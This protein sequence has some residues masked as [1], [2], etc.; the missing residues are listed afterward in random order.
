MKRLLYAIL[1]AGSS[2]VLMPLVIG[3]FFLLYIGIAFFT[4]ETL[5]TLMALTGKSFM[6]AGLL[7]LIPLNNALRMLQESI[8]A[9]KIRRSMAGKTT[10]F[11]AA[12]FDET[13]ELPACPASGQLEK[14][15][16]AEGYTTNRSA[17]ALSAWRGI[18]N[19]PARILL[20]AGM[21]CLFA[22]ILI[23]T[24]TR[25]SQRQMIIEG[26]ALSTPSGSGANV[27][28]ITLANA[29]GPILSRILTIEVASSAS[30][31]RAFGLYPP[32]LYG[33][34][35][36]YPRYLGLALFLGFTA[37]DMQ[38]AY[39]THSFLN[40]Y[41]PGKEDSVSIPDSPYRIIF[42]IPEPDSSSD[43]YISYITGNITLQFKVM[44]DKDAVW[45]GSLPAGGELVH[46]GYRLTLPDVRRMVVTDFIG[47]YGVL[48]IWGAAFLFAAAVCIWLPVRLF[49]PRRE[50]LFLYERDGTRACSRAEGRVRR[51]AG[52]FHEALDLIA[53]EREVPP[54]A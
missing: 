28:R 27:E 31:K 50:M 40:C 8:R 7:A 29:T 43:R 36:V 6:L 44:K 4:D 3:F 25:T 35:F 5:I 23:S 20:F 21:F 33:G 9:M 13:L 11:S 22:G 54:E 26:E 42:S 53:A 1:T 24:T 48:F 18:S 15:L 41:P 30:E 14:R 16:A 32:A 51:H 17:D 19:A 37:P 39:E 10:H 38:N 45:T 49:C 52:V 47:D 46:D 34:S 2:R 12:L